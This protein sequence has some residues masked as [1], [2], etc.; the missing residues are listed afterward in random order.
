MLIP[1]SVN[2]ATVRRRGMST[3]E[4]ALA[5]VDVGQGPIALRCGLFLVIW[6]HY[7]MNRVV[8]PWRFTTQPQFLVHVFR[9]IEAGQIQIASLARI[10][11]PIAKSL[12]RLIIAR[13]RIAISIVDFAD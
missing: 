9:H 12:L 6:T 3:L 8:T 4:I 1:S 10:H 11:E 7:E 2:M 13:I 5:I